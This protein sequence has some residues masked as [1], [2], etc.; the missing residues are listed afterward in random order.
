MEG[1]FHRFGNFDGRCAG[2]L[3][4]HHQQTDTIIEDRITNQGL[5]VGDNRGDIAEQQIGFIDHR[6]FCQVFRRNDG[7]DVLNTQALVGRI[8]PASGAG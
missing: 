2:E 3:F 7:Q 6:D 1:F 8:N 5:M 4:D